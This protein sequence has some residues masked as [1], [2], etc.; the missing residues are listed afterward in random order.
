VG[1]VG[2]VG[3]V[4]E[5]RGDVGYYQYG[6]FVMGVYHYPFATLFGLLLPM[7][8]LALYNLM[9][10]FQGN[11]LSMRISNS[12]FID[13]SLLDYIPTIR[14]QL[15]D[16]PNLLLV[17]VLLYSLAATFHL[18][19]IDSYLVYQDSSYQMDWRTNN[20]FLISLA[21]TLLTV[22]IVL[23]LSLLHKC[24]WEKDYL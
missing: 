10:Y 7:W 22:F 13:L 9:I 18:T 24:C 16:T 12:V 19:M 23:L 11:D 8:S 3:G 17:E 4:R 15:P 1:G 2:Q 14:S 21:V 5:G 20:L 6:H